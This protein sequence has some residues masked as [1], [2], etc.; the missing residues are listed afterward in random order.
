[1][2]HVIDKND[3]E[4]M[5]D[6]MDSHSLV[7]ASSPFEGKKLVWYPSSHYF[8]VVHEKNKSFYYLTSQDARGALT[9][10]VEHYNA[11]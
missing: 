1:M 3:F 10:A 4:S 11:L 7:L 5:M 8:T 9:R 2:A 6:M